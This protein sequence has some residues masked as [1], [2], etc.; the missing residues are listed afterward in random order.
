MA[1]EVLVAVPVIYEKLTSLLS[2]KA[3]I[4]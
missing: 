1:L 4:V 3:T 2:K